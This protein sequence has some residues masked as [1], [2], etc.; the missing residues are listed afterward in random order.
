M[1][2][3]D[4]K[5]KASKVLIGKGEAIRGEKV[6]AQFRK[7]HKIIVCSG[8]STHQIQQTKLEGT[9]YCVIDRPL[10]YLRDIPPKPGDGST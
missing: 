8:S 3:K 6:T 4:L 1:K 2:Q 9:V 7:I 5:K 10:S